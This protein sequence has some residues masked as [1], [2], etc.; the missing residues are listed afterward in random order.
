MDKGTEVAKVV[1]DWS[2]DGF[3]VSVQRMWLCYKITPKHQEY[4]HKSG[5]VGKLVIN[6]DE[7]LDLENEFVDFKIYVSSEASA[8]GIESDAIWDGTPI[9]IDN[10]KLETQRGIAIKPKKT[11]H[12][13]EITDCYNEESFLE[14]VEPKFVSEV[15]G[16]CPN[17][18]SSIGMPNRTIKMCEKK[19][20]MVSFAMKKT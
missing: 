5:Q 18:C 3:S 16:S 7:N 9:M 10:L 11:V 2:D 17:P 15:K 13:K 12:L 19:D 6:V 8:Y 14:V 1:P 4:V 20:Y